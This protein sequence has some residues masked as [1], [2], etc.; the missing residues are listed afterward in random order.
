MGNTYRI[1][2]NHVHIAGRGDMYKENLYWSEKFE[3]G[4]GFKALKVLKGWSFKPVGDHLMVNTLLKQ[5]GKL[6]HVNHLIVLAFDNVYDV[7]GTYRGPFQD[8]VSKSLSTIYVSNKLVSQLCRDNEHLLL[9]LSVH[10]FRPD[11]LE[12][13]ERY[14]DEAVLCKWIASSQSIYMEKDN[15]AAQDKLIAFYQKL[16]E[17]KL[18]LLFHT[19]VETSIP[20]A[21]EGYEQFNSPK[22]IETALDLGVTV[23]LAHCGCSYFDLFQD[24]VVDEVIEFFKRQEEQ[25]LNW[26]LYADISA[27]FSPF[28]SSAILDKIFE[29]IKPEKLIYGSDFPNPAKGRHECFLRPLLRF[30]KA[31][32]LNRSYKISAKWLD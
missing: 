1:V 31:N 4:I 27:L 29:N 3:E 12:E 19:G 11:A 30:R 14:K 25:N 5:A 2:D 10:P 21:Q 24:N 32:L 15:L 8:D 17:I 20:A 23:I 18:P 13:L 26:K 28:R 6:K 22:Y 16:V 7:D 9:G